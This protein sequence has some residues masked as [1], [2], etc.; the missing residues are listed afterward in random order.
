M[1]NYPLDKLEAKFRDS[2]DPER[3]FQMKKYMK[4]RYPFFGIQAN[5][6]RA[7]CSEF[8]KEYGLPEKEI[9]FELEDSGSGIKEEDIPRL[10]DEF[11]RV[12]NDLNQ[13]IKGTGLGLS[14]VRNIV[15]A[16]FGK[17]WV[18]SKVSVGTTFHFTIPLKPPEKIDESKNEKK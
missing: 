8:L 4:D 16:H 2:A 17:I 14:L 1:K 7:I 12:D 3:A 15:E 10:F 9:L 11:Y 18:T 13:N 6:R 5:P